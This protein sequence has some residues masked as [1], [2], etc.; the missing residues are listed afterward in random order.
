MK[1]DKQDQRY[2]NNRQQFSEKNYKQNI[3]PIVDNWPLYVG[4]SNF[5]R[6]LTITELLRDTL[7]V[8]GDIAEFGSWN[9]SNLMLMAKFIKIYNPN[10]NKIVRCFDSFEG[11]TTFDPKDGEASN[12][13]GAYKGNLEV[14]KSMIELYDLVD[15]VSIHKGLIQN[16]LPS[17]ISQNPQISFSFVYLDTDLYEPTKLI[18]EEIA[19]RIMPGGMIVFDQWNDERWPGEGMAANEF[20]AE[21]S[22]KFEVKS[23]QHARQPNLVL[24]RV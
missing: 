23:V 5:A 4:T 1:F 12:D 9:G 24:K 16:T 6:V 21:H 11:L 19:E 15:D 17:L 8:P 22:S 20:L 7:T 14:L 2:L 3:W 13:I 10:C 18:L